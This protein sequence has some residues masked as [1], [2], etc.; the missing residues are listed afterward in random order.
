MG[1]VSR[2][3]APDS[4]HCMPVPLS[5]GV[6]FGG[7]TVKFAVIREGEV[8]DRGNVIDTQAHKSPD[9]LIAAIIGEIR[10]L[11][12]RHQDVSAVGFGVPGLVDQ[13]TGTVVELTN[14]PGWVN[15]PLTARIRQE[16]GGVSVAVDNDANAMTYGEWRFGAAK[17]RRNV[18]CVTLGTGVG[19]GLILDNRIYR[20]SRHA[21]GEIGQI[22][23]D[24]KGVPGHYGNY[25][26]LEKYVGNAQIAERA[27]EL[28]RTVGIDATPEQC[29]PK[30]LEKAAHHGDQLAR[31]L[32]ES[33]GTEIGA[34]LAGVV[35]LL[36]PGCIVIG[37]GIAN[38]GE[39][40]FEPIGRA[41]R[42]RTASIFHEKLAIVPATLGTDAGMIGAAAMA[43]DAAAPGD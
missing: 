8:F 17:N 6:D 39:L 31:D 22:T 42:S 14:V 3:P 18:I 35:W 21:A 7:T 25:G 2:L 40:L 1:T 9:A 20:G 30:N 11:T 24:M 34:A 32:W 23:I 26:A 36:N 13:A 4:T 10:G 41:L 33:F 12:A 27:R 19:G 29:T 15:I 16:L 38:A 37:G 28:Y 43:L 5:I